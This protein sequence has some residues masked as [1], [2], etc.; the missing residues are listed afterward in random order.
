MINIEAAD[1]VVDTETSEV[2]SYRPSYY[3][4]NNIEVFD[5]IDAFGLD[6]Y[7]GNAVKYVCRAGKKDNYAQDLQKAKTYLEVALQKEA[8]KAKE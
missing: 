5:I 6:F 4:R 7:L 3:T 8:N 1:M 2:G